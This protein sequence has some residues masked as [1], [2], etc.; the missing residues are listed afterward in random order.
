M[1]GLTMLDSRAML[2]RLKCPCGHPLS[3]ESAKAVSAAVRDHS[4]VCVWQQ[5]PAA[6]YTLEKA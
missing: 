2:I 3:G 4:S 5:L 1:L 6:S